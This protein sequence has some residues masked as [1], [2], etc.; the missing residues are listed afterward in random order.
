MFK[1]C[2]NHVLTFLRKIMNFLIR[3]LVIFL[4]YSSPSFSKEIKVF[5]FTKIELSELNVRKVRGAK[6]KTIY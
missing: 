5:N 1:S 3:L 2:Q 4:I 6:N